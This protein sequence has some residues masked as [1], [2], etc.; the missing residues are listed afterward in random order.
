MNRINEVRIAKQRPGLKEMI[1]DSL[2]RKYAK[3]E[4]MR[5]KMKKKIMDIYEE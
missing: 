1:M 2:R 3:D 4:K 5:D